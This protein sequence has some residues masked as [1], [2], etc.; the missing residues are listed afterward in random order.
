MVRPLGFSLHV[1]LLSVAACAGAGPQPGDVSTRASS[2][3]PE[4]SSAV[5]DGVYTE[6]QARRGA[7]GYDGAC[8]SCHSANL[9][10]NSNSPSLIGSSFLFF[11][12]D[13]PLQ[14]LFT[15]IRTQMPTN[16]P[17]SLPVQ[18]YLDILAFIMEANDFPAGD[19]ELVAD[20]AVLGRLLITARPGA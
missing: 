12:A 15:A 13:R 7:T 6:D 4:L 2:L 18:S 17:N 19:S 20:P 3:A 9:R 5:W 10:G 8:S 16:A 11:W 1:V 14:E